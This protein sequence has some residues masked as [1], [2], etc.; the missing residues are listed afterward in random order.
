MLALTRTRASAIAALALVG[1][2]TAPAP[3]AGAVHERFS[4][5]ET[6]TFDGA[7]PECFD[8]TLV[9]TNVITEAVSGMRV[10][11]PS[12]SFSVRGTNTLTYRVDFP[13][14]DYVT[15]A[16]KA[17]LVSPGPLTTEHHGRAS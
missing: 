17:T 11:T 14:G 8:E 9:G 15:G 6:E 12:G 13:N 4:F 1:L 2:G 5:T 16:V 3:G 7:L 10:Q